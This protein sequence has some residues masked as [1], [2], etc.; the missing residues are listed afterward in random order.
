MRVMRSQ[1]LKGRRIGG[2][3]E[4]RSEARF[5]LGKRRGPVPTLPQAITKAIFPGAPLGGA[6]GLRRPS[7]LVGLKKG[8]AF[9]LPQG[10]RRGEV[11]NGALAERRERC[12]IVPGNK[13]FIEGR[14]DLLRG[15]KHRPSEGL[16]HPL[17]KPLHPGKA[18]P[19]RLQAIEIEVEPLPIFAAKHG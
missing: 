15:G 13:A 2:L 12:P 4:Q 1:F 9:A 5:G 16:G 11:R 14:V 6:K 7:G 18:V 8:P 19:H 3:R 17:A 10:R